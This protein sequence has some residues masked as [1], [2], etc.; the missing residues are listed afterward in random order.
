MPWVV[1]RIRRGK[2]VVFVNRLWVVR[3]CLDSECL[4]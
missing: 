3:G 1:G 2:G 4:D